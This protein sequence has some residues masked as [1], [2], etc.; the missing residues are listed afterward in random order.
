MRLLTIEQI[1]DIP[2]FAVRD[3]LRADDNRETQRQI[4]VDARKFDALLLNPGAEV[5]A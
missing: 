5:A 3:Q 1:T 2:L 4:A